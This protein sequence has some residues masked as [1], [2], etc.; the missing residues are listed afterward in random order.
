MAEERPPGSCAR[1]RELEHAEGDLASPTAPRCSR[2]R[3]TATVAP[4]R[5]SSASST[6]R[7]PATLLD[8][9]ML[10][11]DE[12]GRRARRCPGHAGSGRVRAAARGDGA[13]EDAPLLLRRRARLR[14]PRRDAALRLRRRRGGEWAPA[15]RDRDRRAGLVR[16]CSRATRPSRPR[17]ASSAAPGRR[18]PRSRWPT[19][20]RSSRRAVARGEG[21]RRAATLPR[22]HVEDLLLLPVLR[23]EAL[24]RPPPEP[25]DGGDEAP[26]Q[27]ESP[28]RPQVNAPPPRRWTAAAEACLRLHALP[29]GRKGHQGLATASGSSGSNLAQWISSLPRPISVGSRSR[30]T[31]S[32]R[33]SD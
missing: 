3:R 9:A 27:P 2:A 6:A 23:E 16:R 28:A 11:L 18:A 19:R 17:S 7:S 20:S 5:S 4:S 33:S 10:A 1:G 14:D 12:A 8:S 31:P 29:E 21:R 13:R 22:P 30:A 25:L 32:P 26:L 24:V 15:G